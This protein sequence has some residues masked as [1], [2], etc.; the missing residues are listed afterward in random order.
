MR[1][2]EGTGGRRESGILG[3]KVRAPS[4]SP[5]HI[6][7]SSLHFTSRCLFGKQVLRNL[8]ADSET[9]IVSVTQSVV[10]AYHCHSLRRQDIVMEESMDSHIKS[11]Y[12]QVSALSLA[13]YVHL[14]NSFCLCLSSFTC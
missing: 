6:L 7:V 4:P 14:I 1:R 2:Q 9:T 12:F 5:K 11:I 10:T 3:L 8:T 13:G